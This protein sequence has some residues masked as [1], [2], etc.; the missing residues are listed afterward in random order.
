M[1]PMNATVTTTKRDRINLRLDK[2]LLDAIDSARK[3]RPGSI[4]RNTWIIEAIEEKLAREGIANNSLIIT[5][6]T[7]G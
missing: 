5:G 2:D 4:S 3:P 7:N 6:R 1:A